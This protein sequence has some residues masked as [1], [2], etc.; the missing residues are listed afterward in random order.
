MNKIPKF[1]RVGRVAPWMEKNEY[2][3]R[4]PQAEALFLYSKENDSDVLCALIDYHAYVSDKFPPGL[5]VLLYEKAKEV[6]PSGFGNQSY[7]IH[8]FNYCRDI[9]DDE[10]RNKYL[11]L[12]IGKSDLLVRWARL[13]NERLPVHLEDSINDPYE[14][15][16]YATDVLKGR[17][18][19]HL[20][21]VF[22]KDIETATR[23]AFEVIRHYA[24]VKL[25][26]HLHNAVVMES[27][28]CPDNTYIKNYVKASENDPNKM[29]NFNWYG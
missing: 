28:K 13:C 11:D 21:N 10:K 15:L 5:E 25:P 7:V 2:Y 17:L 16:D 27:F 8:F 19:V 26:D 12:F 18:P 29:G 1:R 24:S 6:I 9:K 22:H 20:E 3:E 4:I 14:L 23:Y